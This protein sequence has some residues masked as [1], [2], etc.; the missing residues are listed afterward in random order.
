MNFKTFAIVVH[1]SLPF[2]TKAIGTVAQDI[3]NI[4]NQISKRRRLQNTELL[5]FGALE[6]ISKLEEEPESWKAEITK[7][8]NRKFSE[9]A[10]IVSAVLRGHEW[11]SGGA[12]VFDETAFLCGPLLQKL[13]DAQDI[14]RK[15]AVKLAS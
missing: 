6:E 8:F 15:R 12:S 1:E 14:V 13:A 7:V 3:F 5:S 9:H 10:I 4:S 11:S 2:E